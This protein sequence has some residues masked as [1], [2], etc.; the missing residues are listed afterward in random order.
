MKTRF[1]SGV[2]GSAGV[3]GAALGWL[4]SF[5]ILAFWLGPEGV[6]LFAQ[7][8]QL[9]Q[10]ATLVVTY[11]GTNVV[12]Q[13]L[14][15]QDDELSKAR[16][17][18]SAFKLYSLTGLVLMV[19]MLVFAPQL[20]LLVLSSNSSELVAAVRWLALA[21]LL[22]SAA[23]FYLALLNSYHSL[24]YMAVAQSSGPLLLAVVLWTNASEIQASGEFFALALVFC[25]GVGC[26]TGCWGMLRLRI[27]QM[28]F[29]D[30]A[31][32]TPQLA[33]FRRFALFNLLAVISSAMVLLIIRA[34]I[35]EVKGLEFAGLFDAGWTLTFNYTTLLLTACN[36]FYL[37]MLTAA[38]RLEQQKNCILKVAYGV[39]GVLILVCYSMIVW[40]G[41]I[42]NLLYS[43]QFEA[44]GEVL[45]VLVIAVML[46]GVSWVYGTLLV[47]TR[48]AKA[49]L[50]SEVALNL[51][52]L[53]SVRYVLD[54]HAS[55]EALGWAFAGPH[56]LYL[57]FIVEY[58]RRNNP[59]MRRRHIFPFL[60]FSVIPLL[61]LAV[62]P[63]PLLFLSTE[64]LNVIIGL[65]GVLSCGVIY[66]GFRRVAV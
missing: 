30:R 63:A 18:A 9:V 64:Q 21:V 46:R 42:I 32:P 12:V 34:W 24:T 29:R 55:L 60:F 6:G 48:Q 26:I 23:T 43:P 17:R 8:R 44:S 5:K 13:G 40:Q 47:A 14:T 28:E 37:P 22:N 36:A 2:I 19:L 51:C 54:A 62:V 33:E 52:V 39:L 53:V 50:I 59:L 15:S 27:A 20:T 25:F 7:L 49:L 4:L 11:G 31:M 65:L 1:V 57:I 45:S 10:T 61:Y 35:I 41:A 16:F 56:F 58:V 66:R 38:K 3:L